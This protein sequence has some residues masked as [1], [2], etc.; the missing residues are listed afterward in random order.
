V[1]EQPAAEAQGS[2]DAVIE[3]ANGESGLVETPES[4]PK[5][6]RKRTRKPKAEAPEVTS[7]TSGGD[8]PP[9]D[10]AE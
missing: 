8:Q 9:Q 4:A 1:A 7:D 2:F 10:A 5:P 6:K 3:P